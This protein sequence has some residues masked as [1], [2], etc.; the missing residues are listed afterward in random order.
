MG[1][2]GSATL[3]ARL[4]L[5]SDLHKKRR[6]KEDGGT[7]DVLIKYAPSHAGLRAKYPKL[8]IYTPKPLRCVARLQRNKGPA[9][10]A[11]RRAAALPDA[12]YYRSLGSIGH[13]D[14]DDDDGEDD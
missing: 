1:V 4:V 5:S 13:E 2:G 9:R 10:L 3:R 12:P 8:T 7:G 14:D 11:D 6:Q